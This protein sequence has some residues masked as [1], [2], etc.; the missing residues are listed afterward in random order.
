[1]GMG[2][3]GG[4]SY[5]RGFIRMTGGVGVEESAECWERRLGLGDIWGILWECS[6][7]ETFWNL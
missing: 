3:G 1:M 7:V 2:E 6:A 4:G 5:R